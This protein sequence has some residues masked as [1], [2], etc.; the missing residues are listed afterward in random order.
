[1]EWISARDSAD[2]DT[3]KKFRMQI[4]SIKSVIFSVYWRDKSVPSW[5]RPLVYHN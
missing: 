4:L 5:W 1:M 3:Q 2:D